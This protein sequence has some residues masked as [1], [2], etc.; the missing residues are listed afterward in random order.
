MDKVTTDKNEQEEI[1]E[2]SFA[3]LA[4]ALEFICWTVVMLAPLLRLV[5]GPAVT[6]DQWWIQICLF[7]SALA[8]G[9]SLRLYQV[10]SAR[11]NK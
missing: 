10:L 7:S 1:E 3:E 9:L 11:K 5:N 8:G 4:P 2:I 6:D